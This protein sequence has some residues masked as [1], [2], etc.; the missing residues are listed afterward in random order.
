MEK[1]ETLFT[2][3]SVAGNPELAGDSYV[4]NKNNYDEVFR[5]PLLEAQIKKDTL[6]FR[7]EAIVLAAI[8]RKQKERAVAKEHMELIK[9]GDL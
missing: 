5:D 2:A 1:Q 6:R 4:D 9:A 3:I 7:Q 8:E